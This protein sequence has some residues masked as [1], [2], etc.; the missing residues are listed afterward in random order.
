MEREW[1]RCARNISWH[2]AQ[3]VEGI[4]P[5]TSRPPRRE[6]SWRLVLVSR[7]RLQHEEPGD[8]VVQVVPAAL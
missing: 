3:Q 2:S 8:T 7:V 4:I 5:L 6:E 1:G